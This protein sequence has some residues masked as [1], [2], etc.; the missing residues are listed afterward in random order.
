[1][2]IKAHDSKKAATSR[3]DNVSSCRVR[4]SVER[5]GWLQADRLNPADAALFISID[6]SSG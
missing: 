5:D 3:T 4:M 6:S 2:S 1:M